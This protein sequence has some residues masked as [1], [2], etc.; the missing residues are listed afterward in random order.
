M[1]NP[2]RKRVLP[3]LL[4]IGAAAAAGSAR[5]EDQPV[6]PAIGAQVSSV[7]QQ[8]G[9][10]L[11]ASDLSFQV[12]TIRVYQD[13]DGQPL[14]IF[15]TMKV[16]AHR[17]D[18]LAVHVTGDD[19][20]NDLYYDGKTA[21]VFGGNENKY[22][23]IDAPN[24]I[25]AMLDT[26]SNRL[27]VNFPLADLM[28]PSPDKSILS[29]VIS[30]KE[31]GTA[32]IDGKPYRHLFFSQAGGIELELWVDQ[33]ERALLR[34]LIVTY[35]LMPGQPDF[36]AEFSDWNFSAQPSDAAFEFK[37]PAGAKQ[38]ELQAENK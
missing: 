11:S 8:L 17:P 3:A 22:A 15:H 19:G 25:P 5:A 20:V 27:G 35:R 6:K 16:T 33:S 1:L 2:L 36:I 34:R 37:P 38:I 29:D 9:K 18:R 23:K 10:T 31:V 7:L 26:L 28:D 21:V 12:Q 13:K 24:T 4:M 30:G 32:T 14:H